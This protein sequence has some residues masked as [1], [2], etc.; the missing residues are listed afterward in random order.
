LEEKKRIKNKTNIVALKEIN[1]SN[2]SSFN[3]GCLK[4]CHRESVSISNP[5]REVAP[6]VGG[7]KTKNFADLPSRKN[8][9]Y[10]K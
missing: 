1:Q 6:E 7:L 3:E 2:I 5:D 9:C 8:S 10:C 4:I